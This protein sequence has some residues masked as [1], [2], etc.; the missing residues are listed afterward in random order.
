MSKPDKPKTSEVEKVNAAIALEDKKFY[1]EQYLPKLKEFVNRSFNEEESMMNVAEG[2]AQADTMQALTS[3]PNRR[4]MMAVDA[5]ADL[6][7]AASAQAL[8]GTRQGLQAARSDQVT[9]IKMANQM[10]SQTAA[11]LS[12]ASRIATTDTLNKIKAKQ[13]R[14]QG[15]IK[16]GQTLGVAA[17]E[18]YSLKND[19]I[20]DNLFNSGESKEEGQPISGDV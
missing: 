11:G 5:Q 19:P 1:R 3:N 18:Y 10:A 16:A 4:A 14:T 15:L 6:A 20:L 17:G 12:Q 8:Q 9:G 7:S 13:T 2:R